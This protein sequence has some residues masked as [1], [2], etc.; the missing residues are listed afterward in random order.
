MAAIALVLPL[1]NREAS[2]LEIRILSTHEEGSCQ[3]S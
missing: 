3:D 1:A 2:S